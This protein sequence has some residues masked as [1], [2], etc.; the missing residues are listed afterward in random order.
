MFISLKYVHI[1]RF[2]FEFRFLYIE[3]LDIH[4][5]QYFP[6]QSLKIF[7]FHVKSSDLIFFLLGHYPII[8]LT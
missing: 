4:F 1:L 5:L 6:R 7:T 2:Y 3:I 8:K